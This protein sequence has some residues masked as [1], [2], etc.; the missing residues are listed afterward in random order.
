[1]LSR[2]QHLDKKVNSETMSSSLLDKARTSASGI[3]INLS[4]SFHSQRA[5]GNNGDEEQGD[6]QS[7]DTNT[8][9]DS[10]EQ[11]QRKSSKHRNPP[12]LKRLSSRQ[13]SIRQ[14]LSR[15][16]SSNSRG[17]SRSQSFASTNGLNNNNSKNASTEEYQLQEDEILSTQ[18]LEEAHFKQRYAPFSSSFC[19]VQCGVLA[20]MMWQ[21]GVAPMNI[22][23]MVGPYP[24]ALNYWGAK[25]AVLIIEDDEW[26]RLFTPI[27]L[28][29][30]LF[31]LGGNVLVQADSG[32]RWE[33]EWGSIIWIIIYIGSA[34]GSSILSVCA[35]PDQISVGSS[36]AV[37]GLFGGKLAEIFL[38]CC[39]K[40]KTVEEYAG[41]QSR[42]DQAC[43]VIGGIV[44][45]MAMSFIPYVD[46]SAHLGGLV[47][48]FGIGLVC[49]SFKIRMW[50]FMLVWLIVGVGT[51]I[52]LYSGALAYMYNEVEVKDDLRDVCGYYK[53]FFEDYECR[54][55]LDEAI[56][57]GSWGNN[58]NDGAEAGGEKFL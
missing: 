48:G 3:M 10:N 9:A 11:L 36:G 33:K 8:T 16:H 21:C 44:V 7:L 42:K 25:N 32:N 54:C 50:I 38:L 14:Q 19:L 49:F 30:G 53:Q 39:E 26:W 27:F 31:H 46:W 35:M 43:A 41:E 29:A 15:Q 2:S 5:N 28:H 6:V 52:A 22:N 18:S 17:H 1:M 37:M 24:D 20:A 57:W 40:S 55:M 23:P 56:Q 4:Q 51:T 12:I 58:V 47:A 13:M 45:V 34:F